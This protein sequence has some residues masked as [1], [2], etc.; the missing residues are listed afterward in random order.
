MRVKVIEVHSS[1]RTQTTQLQT[2]R[3]QTFTRDMCCLVNNGVNDNQQN[4]IKI[5]SHVHLQ[6]HPQ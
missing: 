1:I 2:F 5:F 3:E 4:Q 6:F